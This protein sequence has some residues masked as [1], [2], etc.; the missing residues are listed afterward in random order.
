MAVSR[1]NWPKFF[2][3]GEKSAGSR[4]HDCRIAD[5]QQIAD[6]DI[7]AIAR[8]SH[9]SETRIAYPSLNAVIGPSL[10]ILARQRNRLE[11]IVSEFEHVPAVRTEAHGVTTRFLRDS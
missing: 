5:P 11:K 9:E 6:G 7:G 4:V 2:G 1:L 3:F 8:Y 10:Y